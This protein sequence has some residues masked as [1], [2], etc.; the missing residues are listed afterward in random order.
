MP[1]PKIHPLGDHALVITSPPPAT[2]SCQARIWQLA[3]LA[4]T[5]EHIV[6]VVP[7][8]NNLTIIFDPLQADPT[9]LARQLDQG[10][11]A[12]AAGAKS[13]LASPKIIDIP[14]RYG[15]DAGP[16]L[17]ALAEHAKMTPRGVAEVHAAT[18]YTVYFL[19]FQPGFAYLG[20]LDAR[21]HM[22]RRAEPRMRVPAGSVA[23]GG[24]QTGVYP[25]A[26]PGG[27]QL[28]GRTDMPL[29]DATRDPASLM[30]AGDQVRFII[31]SIT[32]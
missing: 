2:L 28:I 5:W 16:D 3:K 31:E 7:G 8:M 27:W 18:V 23:I 12:A 6:D 11:D 24:E 21:L 29:F 26:S 19:G 15:G 32:E 14:V 4:H 20:T 25:S 13:Q 30:Q 1:R 9:T 17:G 10:W 22:P